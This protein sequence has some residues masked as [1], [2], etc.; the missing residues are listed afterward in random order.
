MYNLGMTSGGMVSWI[1]HKNTV[2][3]FSKGRGV[4]CV[5]YQPGTSES[6]EDSLHSMFVFRHLVDTAV[7]D[8][9]ARMKER[10]GM[11][12]QNFERLQEFARAK[13]TALEGLRSACSDVHIS[14]DLFYKLQARMEQYMEDNSADNTVLEA[15]AVRKNR[16]L[17]EFRGMTTYL[18]SKHAHIS[19]EVDPNESYEVATHINMTLVHT[20]SEADQL[21]KMKKLV[22]QA[23]SMLVVKEASQKV[24][25]IGSSE[26][27]EQDTADY[28]LVAALYHSRFFTPNAL[29]K[30]SRA[31][32]TYLEELDESGFNLANAGFIIEIAPTIN[33]SDGKTSS[34]EFRNGAE[35]EIEEDIITKLDDW[36]V[37][38][39][40]STFAM[41][42]IK[43]NVGS[44]ASGAKRRRTDQGIEAMTQAILTQQLPLADHTNQLFLLSKD[45]KPELDRPP[46]KDDKPDH[47]PNVLKTFINQEKDSSSMQ[48][49]DLIDQI[50]A[51]IALEQS[52]EPWDDSNGFFKLVPVENDNH[53]VDACVEF[54][55]GPGWCA[56]NAPTSL[57]ES[58]DGLQMFLRHKFYGNKFDTFDAT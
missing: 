51:K 36:S 1:V 48:K 2:S 55:C 32:K 16:L 40:S 45:G 41:P 20:Y 12:E 50:Q 34:I 4:K 24:A 27:Q 31:G 11:V 53:N 39:S 47:L 5:L 18:E 44:A 23:M 29:L 42:S 37:P 57:L 52:N 22:D 49:Q 8:L 35:K 56:G 30:E 33:R 28:S 9:R 7:S 19:K 10:A 54:D 26:L 15:A 14:R 58:F 25:V 46:F 38:F 13:E 6:G 21:E 43:E 17:T 3:D